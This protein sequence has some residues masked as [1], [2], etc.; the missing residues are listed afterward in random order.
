MFLEELYDDGTAQKSALD[1]L[2]EHMEERGM[3]WDEGEA[4]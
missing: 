4:G 2:R 1:Q 3:K